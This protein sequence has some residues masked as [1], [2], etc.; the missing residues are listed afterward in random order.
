MLYATFTAFRMLGKHLCELICALWIALPEINAMT[1]PII[2]ILTREQWHL[3][4]DN[5]FLYMK[6]ASVES[7]NKLG[8]PFIE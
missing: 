5:F 4:I 3:T 7:E 1:E 6:I 8:L 2:G